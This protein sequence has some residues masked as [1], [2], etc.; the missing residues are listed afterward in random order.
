MKRKFPLIVLFLLAS[1]GALG[2]QAKSWWQTNSRP[3]DAGS[4]AKKVTVTIPQGTSAQGIGQILARNGV[5]R[6]PQAWQA[7]SRWLGFQKVS[8]GFQAGTYN[9]STTENLTEVAQKVWKGDVVTQSFTV[10][11]GWS[12]RQM[13]VYFEQQGFF[14]A[15]DFIAATQQV[16]G[17][18]YPWLPPNVPHLEGFLYPDTYQ[19]IAGE[20][21]TPD[22]VIRQMLDRFAQLAL[23]AYK[24]NPAGLN[25]L[26][27][28][29]L[30]SIVEKEAVVAKERPLIAGVFTN[31]LKQGMALGSDPTVEY[32]L[33]IQ[34]TKEQPLT[35]AQVNMP[36]PYNTYMNPGL[37]P[38]PIASPGVES[39]KATINPAATDYLYFMARYDGTH[40]FTKTLGEHE[41]AQNGV[42]D[43]VEAEMAEEAAKAQS[44]IKPTPAPAPPAPANN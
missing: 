14:P 27:W 12:I 1:V 42:R 38:G 31:R 39:L 15:K 9:F 36:S 34:Q 37:P 19:M 16:P 26:Q 24:Q 10:P 33:G 2:W 4:V 29:T 28:V 6:S 32:G 25:L 5:I 30:G 18:E 41:T 3:V 40:I 20:A 21:V 17:R 22:Q 23:P 11:E 43:Q 35:L 44:S 8:G 13:A 7:W